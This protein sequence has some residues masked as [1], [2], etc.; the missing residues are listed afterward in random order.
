MSRSPPVRVVGDRGGGLGGTRCQIEAE[1]VLDRGLDRGLDEGLDSGLN[2]ARRTG[3]GGACDEED[4]D[5]V[6]RGH[7]F[8][9]ED[10]VVAP[11]VDVPPLVRYK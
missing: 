10:A 11:R 9:R 5:E 4:R 2:R 8:A 3:F 1:S 7:G 6:L